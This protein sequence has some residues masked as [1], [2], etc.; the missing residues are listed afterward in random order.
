MSFVYGDK[1]AG[2]VGWM[3][4][5]WHGRIDNSRHW[6]FGQELGVSVGGD[7]VRVEGVEL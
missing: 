1:N 6:R 3:R 2:E 4:T 7:T 5:E